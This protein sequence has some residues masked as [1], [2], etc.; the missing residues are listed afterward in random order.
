ML[1]SSG[2]DE[3]NIGK[4]KSKKSCCKICSVILIISLIFLVIIIVI[5]TKKGKNKITEFFNKN[6]NITQI[7]LQNIPK[8]RLNLINNEL[9]NTYNNGEINVIKFFEEFVTQKSYSPP[10]Y[11]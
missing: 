3:E 8:D 5:A 6:I 10:D 9:I 11:N 2:S 4:F 7:E 1:K